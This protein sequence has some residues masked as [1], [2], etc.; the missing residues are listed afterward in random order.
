MIYQ[1]TANML[2][3]IEDE[4]L[5]FYHDCEL[6]L[7][8]ATVINPGQPNEEY[9]YCEIALSNHELDPNQPSVIIQ[10]ENNMPIP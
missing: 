5:D 4:A 1:V 6:A 7:A 10:Y 3:D 9:S 2:F 8:K